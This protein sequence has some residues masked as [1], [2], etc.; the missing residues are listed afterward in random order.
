MSTTTIDGADIRLPAT[1]LG[2]G[3]RHPAPAY[4]PPGRSHR[5]LPTPAPAPRTHFHGKSGYRDP[6][7]HSF[8]ESARVLA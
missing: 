1:I 5:P 3:P 7:N 4:P 8:R 2:V 6:N